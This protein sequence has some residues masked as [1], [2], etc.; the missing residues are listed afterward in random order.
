MTAWITLVAGVA[1]AVIALAGQQWGTRAANRTRAGELLLE[2]VAQLIALSED[3]RTRAWEATVLGQHHRLDGWDLAGHRL[4]MAR[5]RVLCKDP[6]VL[7]A[8]EEMEESGQDYGSHLRRG[9]ANADEL[10]ALRERNKASIQAL[11]TASSPVIRR[12]LRAV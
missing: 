8:L 1:G 6:A 7:A 11:A 2:Q 4:A 3:F 10:A 12:R 5:V 9:D